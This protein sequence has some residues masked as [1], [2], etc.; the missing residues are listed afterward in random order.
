MARTLLAAVAAGL[1]LVHG[2]PHADRLGVANGK[3]DVVRCGAGRDIVVADAFDRVGRD[4]ETVSLRIS[5]DRTT[6]P[7]QHP[8]EVEPSAASSGFGVVAAF[9]LGRYTDG[10][11]EAI[12]FASSADAGRTWRSGLLP[13]L[14]IG[15]PWARVS[16]PVVTWDAIHSI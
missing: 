14:T 11:A 1:A 16:D 12:G 5:V 4:C 10:A 9:Q 2:T 8:T 3:R 15:G 7:A 6:G 13:E